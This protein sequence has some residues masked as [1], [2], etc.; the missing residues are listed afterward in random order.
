MK[1]KTISVLFLS[2]AL[3]FSITLILVSFGLSK[4]KPNPNSNPELIIF[5]GDLEGNQEVVGCCPNAGPFP[6]YNMTLS[7]KAFETAIP[8]EMTEKPLDGNIFMNVFLDLSEHDRGKRKAMYLVQFWWTEG[9][10]EYFI[11]IRGGDIES[12]KKTKILTVT[13]VDVPC[14]IWIND[15]PK[16]PV[17]VSFNLT[18]KL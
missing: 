10:T 15:L 1:S 3:F 5:E 14:K 16:E 9:D 4:P 18:R 13:F 2:I 8:K 7:E 6:E 11:E 12:N 17:T